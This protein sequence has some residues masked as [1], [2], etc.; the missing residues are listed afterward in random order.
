MIRLKSQIF[1]IDDLLKKHKISKKKRE[2]I[3]IDLFYQAGFYDAD[4]VRYDSDIS[5][6]LTGEN[7]KAYLKGRKD[8]F[9]IPMEN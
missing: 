3:Q 7:K 4:D 6:E 2:E 5:D 9:K 1:E 8:C